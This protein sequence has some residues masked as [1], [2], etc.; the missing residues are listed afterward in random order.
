MLTYICKDAVALLADAP[1]EAEGEVM[2]ADHD[3]ASKALLKRLHIW[4]DAWEVQPLAA[5]KKRNRLIWQRVRKETKGIEDEV[6]KSSIYLGFWIQREK[7]LSAFI[8]VHLIQ[9]VRLPGILRTQ[10]PPKK[11]TSVKFNCLF[12][13]ASIAFW[14]YIFCS[15]QHHWHCWASWTALKCFLCR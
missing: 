11:A 12:C 8:P 4:L 14:V 3:T 7:L 1:L 2:A 6:T 9:L 10:T 15:S 13:V 5:G